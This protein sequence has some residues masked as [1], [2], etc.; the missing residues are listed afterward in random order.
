MRLSDLERQALA[1]AMKSI[2]YPVEI[3]GSRVDDAARGGDIDLIVFAPGMAAEDRFRL[4]L[5]IA[6]AFRSVCDE[7]IDVHV[8]DPH[9]LTSAE[10]AFL[11]VIRRKPLHGVSPALPAARA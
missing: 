3:F 6:V 7:K 11:S 2:D 10:R 5:R 1:Y 8:L 9:D 4:S